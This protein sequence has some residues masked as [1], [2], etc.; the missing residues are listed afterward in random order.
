[1]PLASANSFLCLLLCIRHELSA[2][3]TARQTASWLPPTHS[4]YQHLSCY[5]PRPIFPF[6]SQLVMLSVRRAH[7]SILTLFPF[8]LRIYFLARVCFS[9]VK[10]LLVWNGEFS[11]QR[12]ILQDTVQQ[13]VE[14][15]PRAH[16]I[17]YSSN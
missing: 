7:L 15:G 8:R 17:T 3:K 2:Q 10:K 1:M 6:Y 9:Y 14:E 16:L 5:S 4:H 13:R 11:R 12:Q